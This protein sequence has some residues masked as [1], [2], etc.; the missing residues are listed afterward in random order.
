MIEGRAKPCRCVFEGLD[1]EQESMLGADE[2]D[3]DGRGGRE[4]EGR[5]EMPLRLWQIEDAGLCTRTRRGRRD[6]ASETVPCLVVGKSYHNH[7]HMH[8]CVY[9]SRSELR[10]RGSETRLALSTP[11]NTKPEA[12]KHRRERPLCVLRATDTSDWDWW[13]FWTLL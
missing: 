11:Q 3:G 4:K 1:Q 12:L 5:K 7:N 8:A 9:V 2:A 6:F 10:R 13:D